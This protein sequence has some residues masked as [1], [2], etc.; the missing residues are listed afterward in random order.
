M[1]RKVNLST[2]SRQQKETSKAPFM[3]ELNGAFVL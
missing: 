3:F 2:K 1:C